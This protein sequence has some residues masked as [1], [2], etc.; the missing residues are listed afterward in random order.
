VL[1][2]SAMTLTLSTDSLAAY[3]QPG[4]LLVKA[5]GPNTI[6]NPTI[7][8]GA[9]SAVT[10]TKNGGQSLVAGD[11][12]N[13]QFLWLVYNGTTYDLLNPSSTTTISYATISGNTTLSFV[14]FP[15]QK[16]VIATADISLPAATTIPIGN[17]IQLK[18]TTTGNV[19][20]LP[21][22]ADLIDGV[23]TAYRI[24]SFDTWVITKDTTGW[25][26]TKRGQWNVG[27]MKYSGSPNTLIGFL[28]SSTAPWSRTTYAGLFAEIGT[29][30]GAGDGSTTFGEKFVG[31]APIAAGAASGFV[32]AYTG[33]T[34]S[35]SQFP[36]TSND[37]KYITGATVTV[38][39]S[40]VTGLSNGNYYL[41][42]VDSTHI[43][44]ANTLLN[45]LNGSNIAISG[46]GVNA[47]FTIGGTSR[48]LG[49]IGG[50]DSH[51]QNSTELLQH[52][53]NSVVSGV[54]VFGI[55]DGSN[56]NVA[57][58]S[59]G[60]NRGSLTGN[61]GGSSSMNILGPYVALNSFIK[62]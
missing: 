46:V 55:Y 27:D 38:S 48:A 59:Q 5:L 20:L 22:G 24:P 45:A 23:N 33:V 9:R 31:R 44:F 54:A 62:T 34:V 39:S 37:K 35:G 7:T 47:T 41:I 18:S 11:I 15:S 8:V 19:R 53:H 28:N 50:E 13:N 30:M 10:I 16:N 17:S 32:E 36:V 51:Y 61:F 49:E 58:G 26:L 57:A 4:T 14:D 29:T 6:N 21:N 60:S 12:Q 2:R 25:V 52:Q 43:Q 1:F 40:T 42:R 56:A 3:A